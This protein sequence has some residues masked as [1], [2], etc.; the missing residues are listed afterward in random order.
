MSKWPKASI[1]VVDDNQ[2]LVDAIDVQFSY[3]GFEVIK[4]TD[5]K[6]ALA[7][8]SQIRPD[9]IMADILMPKLDGLAFIKK[10]KESQPDVKVILITGYYPEYE[11][12][13]KAALSAGLADKVIQKGFRCREIE[14]MVYELLAS[15]AEEV[16]YSG[17]AR[18]KVLVVDDEV[19]ITDFLREF[20]LEQGFAVSIAED[21]EEAQAAY[22]SFEPDVIVTDL[23]MPVRDGVWLMKKV[24]QIDLAAN[25]I[26]ITGLDAR[27]T[28]E[29]LKTETGIVSYFSKPFGTADLKRLAS[30]IEQ[31]AKEKRAKAIER[32]KTT[33]KAAKQ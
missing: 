8:S 18:A 26:V 12:A 2:K 32:A 31:L 4:A 10:F 17:D 13:I 11:E 28:L 6:R 29:K 33:S 21:A 30:E 19:E 9:L 7:L 15:S 22:K 24:R 20:F 16:V 3:C 25:V 27:P 1:L 14:Q 23:K 5:S